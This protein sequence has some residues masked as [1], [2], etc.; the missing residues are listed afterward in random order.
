MSAD[1]APV[2]ALRSVSFS[3]E[4]QIETVAAVRD[5]SL[6]VQTG[7]M[8]C[9]QGASG[10]GKSTLLNLI[11]GLD[12]PTEGEIEAGGLRVDRMSEEERT[13]LR[14]TVVGMVF[15][16]H[17][18]ISEFTSIENVALPLEARG[19]APVAAFREAEELLERVGLGGLGKR[20]PSELS[21]GQ[22]QRVG[23]ARALIGGRRLVLADEPTGA[24]DSATSRE[25]FQLLRR[26][27]DEGT[28]VVLCSHDTTASAWADRVLAMNDG[29]I[30][31]L[32][33]V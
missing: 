31:E 12:S 2:L 19:V 10:S 26:L 14:L 3:Y 22:R 15:Q 27:C 7:Q 28:T 23:V 24:L 6:V 29:A 9:I 17:A 32:T 21:G 1:S 13:K 16:E 20:F 11:A 30:A 33:P 25:L 4:S 8:V 5:V 18:L